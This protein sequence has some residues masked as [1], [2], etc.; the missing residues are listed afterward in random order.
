MSTELCECNERFT[1]L[2][3]Y[4]VLRVKVTLS[5]SCRASVAKICGDRGPLKKIQRS[6]S[7]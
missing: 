7:G 3:R 4:T 5:E 6:V 2:Y 1:E